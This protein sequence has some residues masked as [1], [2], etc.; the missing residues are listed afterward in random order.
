MS[1]LND[2]IHAMDSKVNPAT[3]NLLRKVF[4]WLTMLL[5]FVGVPVI[6][7]L[8]GTFA[9]SAPVASWL[10]YAGLLPWL[11]LVIIFGLLWFYFSKWTEE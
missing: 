8:V 10:V 1:K 2:T 7:F 4:A 9:V 5:I 3:G 6:T 11:V